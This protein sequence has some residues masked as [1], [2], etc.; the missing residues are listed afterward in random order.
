M[1]KIKSFYVLAKFDI[2]GRSKSGLDYNIMPIKQLKMYSG[3]VN[4]DSTEKW[5]DVKYS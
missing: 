4:V 5:S 2:E 1:L 3:S